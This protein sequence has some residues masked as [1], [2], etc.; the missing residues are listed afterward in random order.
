MLRIGK[1]TDYALL[2]M[3]QMA[4][5]QEMLLST[6]QLAEM[7]HLPLPTVSKILKMLSDAHL[8]SS[9]RGAEG[10]YRL[11]KNPVEITVADIIA[12]MEGALSVTE[13]CEG[14]GRCAIDSSCMIR[15]NFRVINKKIQALL[16]QFT[17]IDLLKPLSLRGVL[18]V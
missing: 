3:S 16:A 11:A 8:V 15:E 12:A 9:Q 17:I 2:I 13:C 7:L 10:G 5:K 18:D 14:F 1:L 4:K 6:T